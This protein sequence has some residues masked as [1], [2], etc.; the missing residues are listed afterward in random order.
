MK[1]LTRDELIAAAKHVDDV[2]NELLPDDFD[3]V[4]RI[5]QGF[6]SSLPPVVSGNGNGSTQAVSDGAWDGTATRFAQLV[7]AAATNGKP[8][9]H[10]AMLV[11]LQ[12]KDGAV[13]LKKL[14]NAAG[15]ANQH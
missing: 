13:E 5:V 1:R 8:G 4:M 11:W 14:W 6:R 3:A 2:T 7:S 15:V 10:K 12:A 9:Q